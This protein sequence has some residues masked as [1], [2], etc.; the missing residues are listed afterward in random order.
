M[1][2]LFLLFF[3][4]SLSCGA[5]GFK[6]EAE[7][8]AK[9]LKKELLSQVK[10][11][12]AEGG[13]LNAVEF[14]HEN[15]LGLTEE[16]AQK[17]YDMGRTSLKYRNPQNAPEKWMQELLRRADSTTAKKPYAAQVVQN[18]EGQD[19]YISPLYTAAAC[20][21]CHGRPAGALKDK[22]EKLYPSDK[23]TGYGLSEFR[24]FVW[25]KKKDK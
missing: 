3:L 21:Q 13:P 18:P 4:I 24:G 25:V 16:A 15:A 22:L 5:T 8:Q 11:K 2:K 1:P 7:K 9:T 12:M 20:L 10:A 19:V 14:C 17:G 6:A 23:A